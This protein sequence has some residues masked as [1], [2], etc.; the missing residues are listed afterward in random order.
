MEGGGEFGGYED[1]Q[2]FTI[3]R[4][5]VF[6]SWLLCSTHESVLGKDAELYTNPPC[7]LFKREEFR[8]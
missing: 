1:E 4:K 8:T 5:S 6:D 2:V 3:I 7:V